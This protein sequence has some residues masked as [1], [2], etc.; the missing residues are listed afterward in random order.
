MSSLEASG[1]LKGKGVVPAVGVQSEGVQRE[2]TGHV[3][4]FKAA[5]QCFL[6]CCFSNKLMRAKINLV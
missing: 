6:N 1:L 4:S 5:R 3:K 2:L